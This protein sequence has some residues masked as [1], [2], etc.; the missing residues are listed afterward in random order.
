MQE[1][2]QKLS[3]EKTSDRQELLQLCSGLRFVRLP[4]TTTAQVQLLP[5][6]PASATARQCRGC[7]EEQWWPEND[8]HYSQ[9]GFP[10]SCICSVGPA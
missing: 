4:C 2:D 3:S 7:L 10:L 1:V 6:F 9:L 8:R 5:C